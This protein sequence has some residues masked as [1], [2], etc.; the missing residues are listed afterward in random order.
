MGQRVNRRIT[1]RT[2]VGVLMGGVSREREI[3]L[4][5]GG[6]VLGALRAAGYN[7]FGIDAGSDLPAVL[8]RRKVEA[9]FIALHGRYGEDGCVQGL[10]EVMGIPYT[11]SGVLAS[12]LAMDKAAAKRLLERSGVSTPAFA[13][14]SP[15]WKASGLRCPLMVKPSCQG[16]AIGAFVVERKKDL[17]QAVRKAS[18]FGGPVLVEEFIRGRELTV[19]ILEGRTLPVVEIRPLKGFYDYKAKYTKGKTDFITPAPL[20]RAVE[21]KV[22][23]EASGAYAALGCR[24]AARVDVMLDRDERPFVL[25][26]NTVPGLTELSLFPR[27]A[28]AAGMSYGEL[29]VEMLKGAS[30]DRG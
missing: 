6:A 28:A 8:R 25:E 12:A 9:A 24:G 11:G 17:D 14:A 29:V 3:S 7:A 27:A 20:A 1:R 18:R 5:T 23:K 15:G 22:L 21:R 2:R 4:K 19:S 10:L 26:V 30:V 13:V 16:S